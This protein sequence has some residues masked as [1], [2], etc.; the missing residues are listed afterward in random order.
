MIELESPVRVDISD[1]LNGQT[2]EVLMRCV[3]GEILSSCHEWHLVKGIMFLPC[4][5]FDAEYRR[6]SGEVY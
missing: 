3:T 1:R 2:K 5:Y 6:I 4:N